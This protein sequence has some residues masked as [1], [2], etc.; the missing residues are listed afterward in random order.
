MEKLKIL[1]LEDSE[2]DVQ[3]V[4]IELKRYGI[5][6]VS[7]V[8][9]NKVDYCN[10]LDEF[11]PDIILSDHSL[12][13]FDS[14]GAL[15]I[16]NEKELKIPF[17]LVTG[18]VSEEFAVQSILSG[19]SDYILK[20]NLTRLPI[21]VTNT[22]AAYKL[23]KE[24]E[25]IKK[26]NERKNLFLKH[27]VES[28]PILLYVVSIDDDFQIKFASKNV[29]IITGYSS[30]DLLEDTELWYGNIHPE[31][32]DFVMS[33]LENKIKN[34]VS[35]FE[36][37]WKCKNGEYKWFLDNIIVV[38]GENGNRV[39]HGSRIDITK[40]KNADYRKLVF[41]KGM[42]DMLYMLSHKVRHSIAL[43]LGLYNLTEDKTL[44]NDEIKSII[45]YMKEPA[46]SLDLFTREL[47]ALMDD[48]KYLNKDLL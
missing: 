45:A 6:F 44:D 2:Y 33:N 17:I 15:K 31:D 36:Y 28:Q 18:S 4:K 13:Q 39:I 43:I 40:L 34:E 11:Q 25:S 22:V 48:L 7:K 19:A 14:V 46:E 32:K 23:K 38:R 42:D 5:E 27:I 12:P 37:R 47:T 30:A 16:Y 26:S 8:V 1:I 21:A 9:D 35:N 24:K 20:S 41:T 10:A 29:K 3:L